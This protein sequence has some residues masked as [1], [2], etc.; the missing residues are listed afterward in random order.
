MKKTDVVVKQNVILNLFQDLQRLLLLFVNDERGRSR[1]KFGNYALFNERHGER[2][3]YPVGHFIQYGMT[4]L[5]NTPSPA[6][7]VSSP[8]RGEE[9]KWPYTLCIAGGEVNRGFTLIELLVVVLIIG[10]LAAVA[11]PQ[12]QKAVLKSHYTNL[13]VLTRAIAGAEEI[14]YLEHNE[15]TNN[16]DELDIQPLNFTKEYGT[17]TKYRVFDWGYCNVSTTGTSCTNTSAEI[18]TNIYFLHAGN[19]KQCVARNTDLSS[20]QNQI[21]KAETGKETGNVFTDYGYTVWDY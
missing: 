20:L 17:D 14:Y 11:L 7:R 4:P 16:F 8:A 18:G 21:C 12:Y 2:G 13:K 1:T 10:I 19:R 5:F 15:Y 6:L 3:R 9:G